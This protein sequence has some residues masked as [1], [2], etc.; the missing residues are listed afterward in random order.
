MGS[1]R[2]GATAAEAALV[3]EVIGM[4]AGAVARA[5]PEQ[6]SW[7]TGTYVIVLV[8][9]TDRV[10]PAGRPTT[11]EIEN[12]RKSPRTHVSG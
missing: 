7:Y 3:A 8:R 10:E 9:K 2:S 5:A 4:T 12:A 11:R 1:S 6:G